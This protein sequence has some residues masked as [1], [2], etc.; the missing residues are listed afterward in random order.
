MELLDIR[1]RKA[2][3]KCQLDFIWDFVEGTRRFLESLNQQL[4]TKNINVKKMKSD[5][6]NISKL[7]VDIG[8]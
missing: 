8:D 2:C 3:L 6:E 1:G 4:I 7:G 5:G